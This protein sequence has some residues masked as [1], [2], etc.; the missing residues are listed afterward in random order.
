[1]K[2]GIKSRIQVKQSFRARGLTISQWASENGFQRGEVYALLNGRLV[3]NHG[4]AHEI[5][6][7]LQLKADPTNLDQQGDE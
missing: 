6:V 3:G 4:R 1:M 2:N 7:A 5:A